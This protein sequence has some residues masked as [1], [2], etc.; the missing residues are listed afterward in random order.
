MRDDGCLVFVEFP[1]HW[2]I[3]LTKK[4]EQTKKKIVNF[5]LGEFSMS[6][7]FVR[8]EEMVL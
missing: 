2:M 5:F 4:K 7:D 8:N 6:I 1:A 3:E